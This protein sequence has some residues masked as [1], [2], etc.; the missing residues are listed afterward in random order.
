[1]CWTRTNCSG[2][3]SRRRSPLTGVE[4][5]TKGR[6]RRAPARA[7][8]WATPEPPPGLVEAGWFKSC[9]GGQL[10]GF[11]GLPRRTAMD[12]LGLVQPVDGLGQGAVIAVA[13]A[14]DRGLDAGLGEPLGVANT[15]VLRP[16]K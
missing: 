11:L 3:E 6:R 1:M 14:A 2:C 9:R 13:L 4:A 15:D 10:D 16:A 7:G 8:A 12:Q 5:G